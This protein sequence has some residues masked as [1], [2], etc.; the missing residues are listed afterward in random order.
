[1]LLLNESFAQF[2]PLFI[3]GGFFSRGQKLL[4]IASL[5]PSWFCCLPDR[6]Q[7]PSADVLVKKLEEDTDDQGVVISRRWV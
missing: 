5:I 2:V 1:M 4:A 7:L 3:A 6:L